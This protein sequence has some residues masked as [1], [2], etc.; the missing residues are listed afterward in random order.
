MR[1]RELNLTGSDLE[2][3]S[4]SIRYAIFGLALSILGLSMLQP[5]IAGA[6]ETE[7]NDEP[8]PMKRMRI[9]QHT[10]DTA[11]LPKEAAG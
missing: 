7:L 2:S 10:C 3:A 11:S 6:S 9:Y 1:G 5:R 8:Y 4:R